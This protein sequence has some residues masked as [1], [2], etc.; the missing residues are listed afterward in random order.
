[1]QTGFQNMR[2]TIDHKVWLHYN[3]GAQGPGYAKGIGIR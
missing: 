1:V 3:I 2:N